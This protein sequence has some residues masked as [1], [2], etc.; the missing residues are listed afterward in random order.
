VD[1]TLPEPL[2][3]DVALSASVHR[4]MVDGQDLHLT[5]TASYAMLANLEHY[6]EI[7]SSWRPDIYRPIGFSADE[8]ETTPFPQPRLRPAAVLSFSGGLDSSATLVRQMEG[9]AKRDTVD[10][11]MLMLAHGFD[12]PLNEP[13]AFATARTSVERQAARFDLPISIVTL[14]SIFRGAATP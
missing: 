12:L 3:L 5:G 13:S 7:W 2:T 6:V 11:R 14:R 8:I 10:V 1:E 4:A 9:L